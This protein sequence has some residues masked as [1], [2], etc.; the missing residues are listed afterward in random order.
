MSELRNDVPT[1]PQTLGSQQLEPSDESPDGLHD[2]PVSQPVRPWYWLL[3]LL[4][5]IPVVLVGVGINTTFSDRNG[6]ESKT[7]TDLWQLH[8][9]L[10]SAMQELNVTYLP[11]YLVLREDGKY[12]LADRGQVE[13]VSIL[14]KAFG[15]NIDLASEIDWNNDGQITKGPIVL[16]GHHCLVFWLGGIPA[17]SGGAH[18]CLGFSNDPQN[19]AALR[20]MRKGPYFAFKSS[21]LVIDANG[22]L[23]YIDPFRPGMPYAYFSG[24]KSGNRFGGDCAALGLAPYFEVQLGA[25]HF[26]N[27][28]KFQIISAGPDGQFGAGGQWDPAIGAKGADADNI[29]NFARLPLGRPQ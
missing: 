12:D 23:Y 15:K 26:M 6:V 22:F 7:R 20:G 25:Q 8:S 3:V 11:S 1:P 4:A 18:G 24:G 21:R 10:I 16:E 28:G 5:I 19:P 17:T 13:T 27:Q 2:R 29:T 14:H 9:G